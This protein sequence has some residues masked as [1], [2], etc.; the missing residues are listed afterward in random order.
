MTNRQLANLLLS[1]MSYDKAMGLAELARYVEDKAKAAGIVLTRS[2]LTRIAD[3]R[4]LLYVYGVSVTRVLVAVHEDI[5]EAVWELVRSAQPELATV[6]YLLHNWGDVEP[7]LHGPYPDDAARLAAAKDVLAKEGSKAGSISRLDVT[8]GV[9]HVSC[10]INHEME[11]D[12]LVVARDGLTCKECGERMFITDQDISHHFSPDTPSGVDHDRDAHHVAVSDE[13]FGRCDTCGATC[14]GLGCTKERGH[15][16][17]IEGGVPKYAPGV[18]DPKGVIACS[19]NNSSHLPVTTARYLVEFVMNEAY[20]ERSEQEHLA[21]FTAEVQDAMDQHQF[22]E[23]LRYDRIAFEVVSREVLDVAPPNEPETP[24]EAE[25]VK[26]SLVLP[27]GRIMPRGQYVQVTEALRKSWDEHYRRAAQLEGW[28]FTNNSNHELVIARIDV[29][30]EWDDLPFSEPLFAD[31]EEAI[32]HVRKCA[33][34]GSSMHSDAVLLH[35]S[36]LPYTQQSVQFESTE[37]KAEQPYVTT[38]ANAQ[39]HGL[40]ASMAYTQCLHC[41]H[42]VEVN[43]DF[44][45]RN[46]KTDQLGL[47]EYYHL[48]DGEKEH[49]HD[50]VPGLTLT[51]EEWQRI[52]PE[53]FD[54]FEDRKI[55]PNSALF[56][57]YMLKRAQ[58][59]YSVEKGEQPYTLTVETATEKRVLKLQDLPSLLELDST[60]PVIDAPDHKL[61][62]RTVKPIAIR[63]ITVDAASGCEDET[64]NHGAGIR[65]TAADGDGA[66][67]RIFGPRQGHLMNV[68]SLPGGFGIPV[69]PPTPPVVPPEKKPAD[70]ELQV[71][72]TSGCEVHDVMHRV[73]LTNGRVL[74][75][76][77]RNGEIHLGDLDRDSVGSYI[78]SITTGGVLVMPNSGEACEYLTKDVP[79]SPTLMPSP[80]ERLLSLVDSQLKHLKQQLQNKSSMNDLTLAHTHGEQSAY[81]QVKDWLQGM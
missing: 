75:V 55:G 47:S 10:F 60:T 61:V 74:M 62:L 9:P 42:F 11:A 65:I 45:E 22:T 23:D 50:A 59:R 39:R 76:E 25:L 1:S 54:M 70:P 56:D 26:P 77:E 24:E 16:T 27:D 17:A 44:V 80:Q 13:E 36:K 69:T 72:D 67:V 4:V 5:R 52:R 63:Q 7:E 33:E 34:A 46:D 30:E 41:D 2:N 43:E 21:A 32:A 29:P 12:E 66:P 71:A 14:D 73:K 35:D 20:T 49:E 6:H 64:L 28:I 18:I 78:C 68:G 51:G 31:D 57:A 3:E 19:R 38:S 81:D 8:N 79:C 40:V 15:E 58:V 48:D 37:F 53:L